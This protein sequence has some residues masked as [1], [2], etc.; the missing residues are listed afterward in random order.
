M[1]FIEDSA[2]PEQLFSVPAKP[3]FGAPFEFEV[4]EF[5]GTTGYAEF[6]NSKYVLLDPPPNKTHY[7]I[8]FDVNDDTDK[9]KHHPKTVGQHRA[10]CFSR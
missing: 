9:G 5:D 8:P 10:G 6:A 7:A 1:R 3:L 4:V 2:P